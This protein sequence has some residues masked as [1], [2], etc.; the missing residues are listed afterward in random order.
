VRQERDQRDGSLLAGQID[1]F[2]HFVVRDGVR[3][4]HHLAGEGYGRPIER[5]QASRGLDQPLDL[6]PVTAGPDEVLGSDFPGVT[7]TVGIGGGPPGKCAKPGVE[8]ITAAV[9]GIQ[10]E[11]P[12]RSYRKWA[13]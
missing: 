8:P 3:F 4:E 13:G 5:G 11:H 7:A 10:L 6:R 9:K 1:Q 12:S 2:P